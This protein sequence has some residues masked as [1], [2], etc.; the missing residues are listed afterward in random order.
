MVVW[1]TCC[2]NLEKGV[3]SML[4]VSNSVSCLVL[5]FSFLSSAVECFCKL[6]MKRA[7]TPFYAAAIQMDLY[8]ENSS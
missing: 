6:K 8:S 7:E 2:G 5:F 4:L 1:V 3:I